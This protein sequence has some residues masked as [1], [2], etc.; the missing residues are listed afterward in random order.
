MSIR[1]RRF[2]GHNIARLPAL[3][4]CA[5]TESGS[6]PGASNRA[7]WRS[8]PRGNCDGYSPRTRTPC[9]SSVLTGPRR[10]TR[11]RA[12]PA[13]RTAGQVAAPAANNAELAVHRLVP[14]YPT[15]CLNQAC[16]GAQSSPGKWCTGMRMRAGVAGLSG[17]AR[18]VAGFRDRGSGRTRSGRPKLLMGC[19][20]AGVTGRP[21]DLPGCAASANP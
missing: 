5:A 13:L 16:L 17:G 20:P 2:H 10:G 15:A 9:Q 18:S 1:G 19:E 3:R 4:T 7:S 14:A 8:R 6:A 12:E 11:H 21:C